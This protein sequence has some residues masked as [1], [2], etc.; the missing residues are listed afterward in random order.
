ML[1][2]FV[3]FLW[4]VWVGGYVVSGFLPVFGVIMLW[5]GLAFAVFGLVSAVLWALMLVG[6]FDWVVCWI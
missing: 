1:V 4:G 3:I 6:L 2:C 5:M